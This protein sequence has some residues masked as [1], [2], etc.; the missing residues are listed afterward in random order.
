MESGSAFRLNTKGRR[1]GRLRRP[2]ELRGDQG[3]SRTRIYFAVARGKG[4]AA[5][6]FTLA[7]SPARLAPAL[8]PVKVGILPTS[9]EPGARFPALHLGLPRDDG[10]R[11][12]RDSRGPG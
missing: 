5:I 8:V 3:S 4:D 12:A 10:V 11:G 9:S 6:T 2:F 7:L 1:G